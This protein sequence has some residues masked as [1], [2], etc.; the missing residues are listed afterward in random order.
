MKLTFSINP[1][2]EEETI[3]ISAKAITPQIEKIMA[4]CNQQ[5][6]D[7]ITVVKDDRSYLLKVAEIPFLV[8]PLNEIFFKS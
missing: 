7:L 2:I 4:L 5:E 3:H 8:I 6:T 1:N